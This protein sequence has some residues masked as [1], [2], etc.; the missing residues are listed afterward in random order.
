[1]KSF[2]ISA[3][4][5]IALVIACGI[6]ALGYAAMHREAFGVTRFAAFLVITVAAARLNV[7]LPGIDGSMSVNLPFILIALTQLS[8]L[9]TVVIA[10]CSALIQCFWNGRK[11]DAVKVLFNVCNMANSVAL[12][13]VVYNLVGAGSPVVTKTLLLAAAAATYFIVNTAPVAIVIGLVE[14][15]SALLTWSNVF[16]WTYPYYLASAGVASMVNGMSHI[17]GWQTPLLVV[18]VV[19][20]VY[21]SYK[22]YF[23]SSQQEKLSDPQKLR[24][25]AAHN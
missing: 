7:R 13:Y 8:L 17:V 21:C 2:S 24:A 12:A 16:L 23:S 9:E 5:F 14:K 25:S 15:K 11:T 4:L 10:C 18:P 20:G 22:K 3:K 1:M 19:Y 6:G